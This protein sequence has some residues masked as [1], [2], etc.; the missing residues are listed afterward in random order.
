MTEA[1]ERIEDKIK[2]MIVECCFLEIEPS[3]IGDDEVL[4]KRWDIDSLKLFEI[5]LGT[6]DEFDILVMDEDFTVDNFRTV[7]DIAD[8]VRRNTQ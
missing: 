3:E 4:I 6:E 8:C 5:V 2:R 7:R 1:N